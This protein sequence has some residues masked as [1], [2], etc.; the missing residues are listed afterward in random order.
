MLAMPP[1]R[2]QESPHFVSTTS[3]EDDDAWLDGHERERE[4]RHELLPIMREQDENENEEEYA[5]DIVGAAGA[6]T[7]GHLPSCLLNDSSDEE[8]EHA[9]ALPLR[10]KRESSHPIDGDDW[11]DQEEQ[12]HHE[13]QQ[14]KSVPQASWFRRRRPVPRPRESSHTASTSDDWLDEHE[15]PSRNLYPA[16]RP[17]QDEKEEAECVSDIVGAADAGTDAGTGGHLPS[18]LLNDLSED[19]EAHVGALPLREKRE[20]SHPIDQDDWLDQ[21][22][23]DPREQQQPKSVPQA[24]WFRR[25]RS[26]SPPSARTDGSSNTISNSSI[27]NSKSLNQSERQSPRFSRSPTKAL[28]SS[29]RG[30]RRHFFSS[31]PALEAN[32]F[33]S[34]RPAAADFGIDNDNDWPKEEGSSN[35]NNNEVQAPLTKFGLF[36]RT[37]LTNSAGAM[38]E[39]G[40][41]RPRAE[42]EAT[43]SLMDELSIL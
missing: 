40:N 15:T 19:A 13:Q 25:R 20:S 36:R 3:N 5:S 4:H 31:P 37:S 10:E 23:H 33:A 16:I 28:S 29:D 7:G 11:L 38:T 35:T 21:K 18:R 27:N 22:E 32:R 34:Q 9:G 12:D 39:S 24:S 2:P 42:T 8:E 1:L 30:S 43:A 6:G 41:L 14:P 26:V 17:E